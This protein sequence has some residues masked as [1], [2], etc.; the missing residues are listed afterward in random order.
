MKH[1]I[2]TKRDYEAF[3]TAQMQLYGQHV[4]RAYGIPEKYDHPYVEVPVYPKVSFM[5]AGE[6]AMSPK[7]ERIVFV[8]ETFKFFDGPMINVWVRK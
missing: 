2:G 3:I 8:E 4:R 1:P 6:D 5:S 7:L